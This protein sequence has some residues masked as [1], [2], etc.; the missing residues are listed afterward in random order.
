ML[1]KCVNYFFECVNYLKNLKWNLIKVREVVCISILY[2]LSTSK[3]QC[4]K[5]NENV[6]VE[7]RKEIK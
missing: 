6:D 1:F 7:L 5:F 4:I 3:Y 2:F